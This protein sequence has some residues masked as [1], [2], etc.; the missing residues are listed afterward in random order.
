MQ[1]IWILDCSIPSPY[2]ALSR[3]ARDPNNAGLS[4]PYMA[5]RPASP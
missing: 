4:C 2:L 5:A 3:P 1:P